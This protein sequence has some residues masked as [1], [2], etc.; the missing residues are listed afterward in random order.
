MQT[1]KLLF[2]PIFLSFSCYAQSVL[3]I[4]KVNGE[5]ISKCRDSLEGKICH[6][7]L[8]L[9][10]WLTRSSFLVGEYETVNLSFDGNWKATYY[11]GSYIKN[12]EDTF[13]LRPVYNYDTI[14][15]AL[16]KNRIFLLPDQ[17]DLIL[18]GAVDDGND[19]M[20]TFKAGNKFRT[21]EFSNPDIYRE[22]N[23]NIKELENYVNIINILFAWLA[24]D[25][26]G[27]TDK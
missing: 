11:E 18:E 1:M 25:D 12:K 16:K 9:E 22:Y 3:E 26:T 14:F 7:K 5:D 10:I 8:P 4:G 15:A 20:L 27:G 13:N 19:Y 2:I 23:D 21:Y 6:S 24:K 17:A